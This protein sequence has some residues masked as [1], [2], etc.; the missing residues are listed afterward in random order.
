MGSGDPPN[1]PFLQEVPE[2]HEPDKSS[3][4]TSPKQLYKRA[5]KGVRSAAK[6]VLPGGKKHAR[7]PSVNP[8]NLA[9]NAASRKA[10]KERESQV[11]SRMYA[12]R[13]CATQYS[14]EVPQLY[15]AWMTSHPVSCSCPDCATDRRLRDALATHLAF[16]FLKIGFGTDQPRKAAF[17]VL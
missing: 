7:R 16:S 1:S 8:L 5:K 3:A 15:Y 9:A 4:L 13:I 6:R 11:R 17:S 10:Q 14:F 2:N 12:C